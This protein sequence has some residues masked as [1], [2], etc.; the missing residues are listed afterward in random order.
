MQNKVQLQWRFSC[1][2]KGWLGSLVF[3]KFL[4]FFT[5]LFSLIPKRFSKNTLEY[6]FNDLNYF[7]H[8]MRK[9]FKNIFKYELKLASKIIEAS[10]GHMSEGLSRLSK[11]LE[12]KLMY[13]TK[14]LTC[15]ELVKNSKFHFSSYRLFLCFDCKLASI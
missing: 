8:Y 9:I 12:L 15:Y 4:I 13:K 6:F 2:I 10:S 3:C 5:L 11:L 7:A 1:T 14:L